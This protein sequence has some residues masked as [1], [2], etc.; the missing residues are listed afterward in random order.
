MWFLDF[1][2]RD[3]M[4]VFIYVPPEKDRGTIF[5]NYPVMPANVL[6]FSYF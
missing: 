1:G 2:H 3:D 5:M 6:I 4:Q